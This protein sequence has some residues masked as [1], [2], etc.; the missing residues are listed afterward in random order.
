MI[1]SK[2]V[3]AKRKEGALDEAY[4]MAIQLMNNPQ[5]TDWDGKAFA[6]CVIDLIKRD[7]KVKNQQNLPYYLQQLESIDVDPADD[8][9]SKQRLYAIKLCSPNGQLIAQ[10]KVLSKEGNHLDATKLYRQILSSG[11]YSEDVQTGLAWE[12]YRLSKAMLIQEHPHFNDVKHHINDY[13]KLQVE[14]PSL[15]HTCFLQLADKLAIEG[16]LHMGAFARYWNLENLRSEDYDQYKADNGS[17]YPSL[18]ERV[19]QHACK[20]AVGRDAKEELNYLFP[21]INVCINYFPDN[22]WLKLNK[23]K[24]LLGLKR[25]DDALSFGLEVVKS[26]VNDYWAWELLGDIYQAVAPESTFNCYCKA[27]LCSSDINFVGKVKIK[28]AE[29]LVNRQD[30]ARAKFEVDG[31]V[32][33]RIK[34]NQKVPEPAKYLMAQPWYESTSA[35]SSNHDLYLLHATDAESLLFSNLPW[36]DGVLGECFTIEARPNKPRRKLY[37]SASPIPFEVSIPEHKVTVTRGVPGM[38][39]KLKGEYDSEKRY[40]VYTVEKRES[41]INWDIFIDH[42]GVV[43]HV[44]TSKNILHFIV[45][46]NLDGVIRFSDLDEAFSEGDAI[47]VRLSQYTTKQGTRYRVLMSKKTDETVSNSIFKN[48]EDEV[49]EG[50]GMGFTSNGVFIPPNLMNI[51]QIKHDDRVTG[52]AVLNYNKKRSEWGWKAVVIDLAVSAYGVNLNE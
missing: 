48:F 45:D 24:V 40:Q 50:S 6:W 39:I 42:V 28:L 49:R 43:D 9:L 10:A 1:S 32:N 13:L 18:A 19:V 11:D 35:V 46:R 21:F 12:L 30:F 17:V 8:I 27:L 2:E 31:I 20:D 44:N 15:L 52:K 29:L 47:A 23:A 37:V 26:K 22:I 3:F 34:H 7:A 38:P 5:R 14:K 36:I 33:Y 4:Q 25:S 16:K 41:A 51:H